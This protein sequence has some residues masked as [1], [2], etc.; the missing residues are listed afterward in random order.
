MNLS[1]TELSVIFCV[2]LLFS[3]SFSMLE[4]AVIS[5]DKHRLQHLTDEGDKQAL[6]MQRLLGR[7]DRLLS[8]LLLCNNLANVTCAAAATAI[9]ARL[10]PGTDTA[11][12]WVTLIVTFILLVFSEITPKV[13]GVR[14]ASAIALTLAHTLDLL[15]RALL[16]L[17][18]IANFFS[19]LLLQIGGIKKS[20]NWSS[21]L[22]MRELRSVVRAAGRADDNPDYYQLLE[23]T[24]RFNELTVEKIM[25]PRHAIRGIN[26]Q[27]DSADI[28][29]QINDIPHN[30]LPLFAGNIDN[31]LGVIDT[32]KALQL[33]HRGQ[34]TAKVLRTLAEPVHYIPAA[35][36]AMQQ[37]QTMRR[38]RQRTALVADGSGRIVGM[39][40]FTNFAAAIIGEEEPTASN[41]RHDGAIVV[42]GDTT[43][44][45]LE[46]LQHSA[47]LPEGISAT[48]VSGMIVEYLG[49]VPANPL[50]IEINHWRLEI[51]STDDKSVQQVALLPPAQTEK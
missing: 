43:L 49:D 20:G 4:A 28:I 37:L 5:Q 33:A 50:C 18:S 16:P 2:S 11:L 24:L 1:F 21:T 29:R 15:T 9:A 34:L 35:A 8:T 38:Q 41:R 10:L 30:K 12:L 32:V 25:T 13:I 46:Q 44:L 19:N 27:D 23:K 7:T 47:P 51:I 22:N 39:L 45:Q 14:Y 42:S 31:T 3:G 17:T 36:D 26:L 6:M 40:T 48:T